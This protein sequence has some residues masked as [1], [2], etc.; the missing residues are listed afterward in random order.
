MM[1]DLDHFKKYNDSYGHQTGDKLLKEFAHLTQK[2]IR[3]NDILVRYGGEEFF[4]IM[5]NCDQPQAMEVAERIRTALEKELQLEYQ[6]TASFGVSTYD[7]Q[8]TQIQ[9]SKLLA[10]L[11][12]ESDQALYTA[13]KNGRN[14]ARH[15]TPR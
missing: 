3:V 2:H 12:E 1:M 6:I 8:S 11:I 10:K 14:C 13:K 7:F 5:P 9:D 15:F 4:V